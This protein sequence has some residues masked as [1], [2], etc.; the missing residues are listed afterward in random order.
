MA[1]TPPD[2]FVPVELGQGFSDLLGPLFERPT[3]L[4]PRYGFYVEEHHL[5]PALICH[6]GMLLTVMDKAI[7][8]SVLHAAPQILAAPTIQV[9][10]DMVAPGMLG[11]WLETET[12][13]VHTT[14]NLGFA[15]ALLHGR[16]GIVV[17]ATGICKLKS[18]PFVPDAPL[19]RASD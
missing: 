10:C 5:N 16:G 11:D 8:R 17:R 3:E 19:R 14:R 18:T 12:T 13:H 6:G 15:S 7:G 2:G 9:S 1:Q 4:G